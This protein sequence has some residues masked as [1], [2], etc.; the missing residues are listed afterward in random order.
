MLAAGCYALRS[1]SLSPMPLS[2][3]MRQQELADAL[4]LLNAKAADEAAA[5]ASD[6][7]RLEGVVKSLEGRVAQVGAGCCCLR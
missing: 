3:S 1:P 2:L 7:K 4:H 5:A 6:R